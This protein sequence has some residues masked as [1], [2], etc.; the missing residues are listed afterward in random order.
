MKL[1][2]LNFYP[3]VISRNALKSEEMFFAFGFHRD[4]GYLLVSDSS[5]AESFVKINN[6]EE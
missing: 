4:I 1:N 2:Q 3:N 6:A 5:L